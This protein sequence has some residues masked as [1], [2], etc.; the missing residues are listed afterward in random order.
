MNQFAVIGGGAVGLSIAYE[1]ARSGCKVVV[2]ER[3][4]C[5][6][7]ASWAGGGILPAAVFDPKDH[8]YEKLAGLSAKLHRQWAEELKAA[9]G[10]DT[11]YHRCGEIFFKHEAIS[12][13]PLTRDLPSLSARGIRA[14]L[15][16]AKALKHLEPNLA[17]APADLDDLQVYHTPNSAQIRNPRHLQALKAALLQMGV[18]VIEQAEVQSFEVKGD[19]LHAVQTTAGRFVAD[20]FCLAAGAW[21]SHL[22][23]RLDCA[24]PVKPI[25]GQMALLQMEEPLLRN[26]VHQGGHYLI[27]RLDGRMLVGSTLEDVG[28]EKKTT[29]AAI[30]Q[31]LQ[32]A[33]TRLPL[34]RDA[35]VEKCWAGFR[36]A[37]PDGYPFI[38]ALPG[39]A[40]A[41]V[42]AGH[43]RWGLFLSTG[44]AVLMKQ[45][46]KGEDLSLPLDDFRLTRNAES[47][48]PL[49]RSDR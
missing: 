25:R 30:A 47:M 39:F 19:Y 26:V 27:P 21:T 49:G 3:G 16:S 31:L 22:T 6:Q 7:E 5:G 17:I 23:N 14:E 18:S 42:A 13:D 28:F 36:P 12:G 9:T 43:F 8:A 1:F 15:L 2:I 44:T 48:M 46:I 33:K 29:D 32:F 37:S 38:D 20:R 35:S 10:I 11:G 34:L 45:L 41:W 40:N 4:L 24:L